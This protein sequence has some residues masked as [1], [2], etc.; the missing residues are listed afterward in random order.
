MPGDRLTELIGLVGGVTPEADLTD[1][2]IIRGRETKFVV[3][4][5]PIFDDNNLEANVPVKPGDTVIIP[6]HQREVLVFGYV[7]AP[8]RYP[9]ADGET[10]M[11][12]L[13]QIGGFDEKAGLHK[14]AL[15]RREGQEAKV[16]VVDMRKVIMGQTLDRNYVLQDGDV[17]MVPRK[18]GMDWQTIVTQL[19]Q[20]V[21]LVKILQQ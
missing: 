14:T 6:R 21:T 13:A 3:N 8:G 10:L 18:A 9:I 5:K 4:A 2:Q 17:V 11:E 19:F 12:L 15:I 16:F 1:V 7:K 20:T